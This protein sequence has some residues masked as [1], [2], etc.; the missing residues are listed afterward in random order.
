M[1]QISA[2]PR[3]A[4]MYGNAP[5]TRFQ[6]PTNMVMKNLRSVVAADGTKL[7]EVAKVTIYI[8][9]PRDVPKPRAILLGHFGENPPG[10]SGDCIGFQ[11]R[12]HGLAT[13]GR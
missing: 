5:P 6:A 9:N 4:G 12:R 1:A 8:C 10:I 3:V 7:S 11:T 2:R 13:Q